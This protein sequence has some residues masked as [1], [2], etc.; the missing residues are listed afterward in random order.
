M[1][2]RRREPGMSMTGVVNSP[3]MASLYSSLRTKG[4]PGKKASREDSDDAQEDIDVTTFDEHEL[5]QLEAV[6]EILKSKAAKMD[7]MASDTVG[8]AD[9]EE[10]ELVQL[11]AVVEILKSKADSTRDLETSRLYKGGDYS[12]ASDI[13]RRLEPRPVSESFPADQLAKED[14]V[15]SGVLHLK[16][17]VT[18]TSLSE[19]DALEVDGIWS[20]D[21]LCRHLEFLECH[22]PRQSEDTSRQW[23]DAFLYLVAAMK[24]GGMN[25]VLNAGPQSSDPS[26]NPSLDTRCGGDDWTVVATS[27]EK[28]AML[29]RRPRLQALD[30]NDR[31]LFVSRDRGP[32]QVLASYIPPAVRGMAACARRVGKTTIR[33]VLTNGH[34]WIFL[35][36]TLHQ[37]GVGGTY[38]ATD[39]VPVHTLHDRFFT[40]VISRE[41]VK[42]VSA[43]V[44]YWLVH[45]HEPLDAD[46]DFFSVGY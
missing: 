2:Q 1:P 19:V 44:A 40:R 45:S 30:E 13:R 16:P 6:L 3:A 23:I 11:E 7:R 29:M 33:G 37:D 20:L 25:V 39:V 4:R 24:P 32:N 31:V 15:F 5:A 21:M 36:L 8:V 43:V 22:V 26:D 27:L 46:E 34:E 17:G 38:Q 42:F 9:F 35:I 14:F 10:E 28:S 41:A 18:S 12:T